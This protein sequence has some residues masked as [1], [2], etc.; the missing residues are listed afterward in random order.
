MRHQKNNYLRVLA[1]F[2]LVFVSQ[3]ILRAQTP[4]GV[5][6]RLKLQE[7]NICNQS[8]TPIQLRGMSTHGL[9]YRGNCYTD[10][11]LDVLVNQWG[12]DIIRLSM[13]VQEGGYENNPTYWKQFV[14]NLVEKVYA[15]GVYCMLDWHMLHPG[16][17]NANTELAKDFFQHMSAKH[18]NKGNIIYEICNE[19]NDDNH[20]VTWPMIKNYAEK[21]IPI[22][23]NNDPNS[24][25]VVGTPKF[26]AR[27][28]D[29]I[30]NKLNYSNI[31]YTTH[32]YVADANQNTIMNN[33]KAAIAAGVPVFV[34]EWGTQ[35]GWGDGANDFVKA[36]QWIDYMA[37]NKISWC[38]WNYSDSPLSGATWKTGT[39]PNGPWIDANL[40]ESGVWMKANV[41]NPPDSWVDNNN[42]N[43]IITPVQNGTYTLK[44]GVPFSFSVTPQVA[45]ILLYNSNTWIN[46]ATLASPFAYTWFPPS[47]GSH[48]VQY[49]FYDG[50]GN[51]LSGGSRTI[52]VTST[53][54]VYFTK[55]SQNSSVSGNIH[56]N[57]FSSDPNAGTSDGKGISNVKFELI[58]GTSVIDSRLENIVPYDWYAN[59]ANYPDGTYTLKATATSTSSAGGDVN[60]VS[61]P[62]KISNSA[63][64]ATT[65]SGNDMVSVVNVYPV[66]AN[67]AVT[68]TFNLK[69]TSSVELGL[70]TIGGECIKI[71]ENKKLNPGDYSYTWNTSTHNNGLYF[72]Q[73]KMNHHHASGKVVLVK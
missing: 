25:I 8:G 7:V 6:G 9:Q 4:F 63:N 24:L 40:K 34:T 73:L 5:N 61:I 44:S 65:E 67:N 22:I 14:D 35:N 30:G 20:V 1:L 51:L 29:V 19:P 41:N 32:V 26:C 59:T 71:L 52:S 68:L 13:Y 16:D 17:P 43:N 53:S 39:C 50:N 62:L 23:R 47:S 11:S 55:P 54:T 66:P 21:I 27:P 10:A 46:F 64:R 69:K 60:A 36:K 15:R 48:V 72:Y 18:G 42:S 31:L 3:H 37:A 38:N 2:M 56:I 58:K 12:V 70:Y 45:K 28:N 49:E 57:A 33:T